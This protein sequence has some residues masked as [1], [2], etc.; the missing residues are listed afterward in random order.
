MPDIDAVRRN[1]FMVSSYGP[2]RTYGLI[3]ASR[4][5]RLWLALRENRP[6]RPKH[7]SDQNAQYDVV[8]VHGVVPT[9]QTSAL[10]GH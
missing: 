4:P 3:A 2:A 7:A 8:K 6:R 1:Q 10:W 9:A 5:L